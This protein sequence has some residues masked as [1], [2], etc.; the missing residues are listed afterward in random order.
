MNEYRP[1]SILK[2]GLEFREDKQPFL[3]DI[4]SLLYDFELLHDFAVILA[5]KE[6][7]DYSLSQRFFW[8][9]KGRPIKTEHRLKSSKIIKKSPLIIE[10]VIGAVG[11][12]WILIQAMDKV[13]SWK[14]NRKKLRLE[15]EKIELEIK[16]LKNGEEISRITLEYEI[17]RREAFKTLNALVQRLNTNPIKLVDISVIEDKKEEENAG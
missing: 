1:K 2:L 13:S 4:S 8:L 10:L 3:L 16:K 17:Q 15:I 12:I 14:L 9:R 11:A 7:F 6:Y 5:Y